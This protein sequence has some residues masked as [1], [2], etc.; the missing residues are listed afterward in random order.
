VIVPALAVP[1]SAIMARAASA[2]RIR[3][4]RVII[5]PCESSLSSKAPKA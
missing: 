4:E 5:S 3:F 1:A 2:A